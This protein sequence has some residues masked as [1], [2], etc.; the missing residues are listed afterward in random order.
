MRLT[1][2]GTYGIRILNM[3][4]FKDDSNFSQVYDYYTFAC[5]YNLFVDQRLDC[6][7]DCLSDF[8][9]E[10]QKWKVT[11]VETTTADRLEAEMITAFSWFHQIIV[12]LLKSPACIA[13]WMQ[14]ELLLLFSELTS[15]YQ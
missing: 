11:W 6:L 9:I 2:V 10:W 1:K 7:R 14:F 4:G 15:L 3:V 5:T 13:D 12:L 8:N